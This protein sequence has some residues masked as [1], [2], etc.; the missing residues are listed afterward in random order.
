MFNYFC[1]GYCT[2]N[3]EVGSRMYNIDQWGSRDLCIHPRDFFYSRNSENALK[4][5]GHIFCS[6]VVLRSNLARVV[7]VKIHIFPGV[8]RSKGQRTLKIIFV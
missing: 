1:L 2:I 3:N 4:V 8:D 5:R 7:K 6:G